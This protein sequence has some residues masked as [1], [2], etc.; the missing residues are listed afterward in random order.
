MDRRLTVDEC[1]A[2]ARAAGTPIVSISG[3][4]PL[5]H[6][7]I[8]EIVRAL[9]DDRRYIYLCTNG[10]L[11]Q[12]SLDRFPRSRR[13]AFVVHLDGTAA[14]HDQITQRPGSYDIA[15][16]AIREAVAR[17][18]RVC[19]NT[20]LFHDS[21]VDDLNQLFPT[22]SRLG[23]EG[24]MISAGYSYEDVPNQEVFLRRRES[25]ERFRRILD[26][27]SDLPFY[28][29]PLYLDFLR[30]ERTYDCA[31]WTTATFTVLGWR[32]PCYALADRHVDDIEG[33]LADEVW[34]AYG[35]GKDPRCT[36]CRMHSSFEGASLLHA[37][38]HPRELL[39][40]AG[41]VRR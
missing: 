30:G 29:N 19:T 7:Q 35:P 5:L 26:P 3:G 9:I 32:L 22:V 11:L 2:A 41:A 13:L 38:R 27:A 18:Y 10:L 15:V 36:D 34:E 23:V 40:L 4:E 12:E 14:I 8:G 20:T 33:L 31:A 21:D 6:R 37:L 16:S 17:G 39:R 1:L 25:I 28:N 24:L